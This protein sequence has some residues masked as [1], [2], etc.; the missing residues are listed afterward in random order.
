[1]SWYLVA[2]SGPNAGSA[3]ELMGSSITIGRAAD[4]DIVL[5]DTMVSRHHARLDKQVNTMS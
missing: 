5:D 1:M 4:N 3:F 2:S